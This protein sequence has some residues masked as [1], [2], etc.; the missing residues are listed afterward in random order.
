MSLSDGVFE[1]TKTH[2]EIREPSSRSRGMPARSARSGW[3]G[4][5]TRVSD[6]CATS[7]F[8]YQ[9]PLESY[10]QQDFF[11]QGVYGSVSL[12]DGVIEYAK[13]REG[14][15]GAFLMVQMNADQIYPGWGGD[16]RL[17]G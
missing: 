5:A 10:G 14:I 3:R 9:R 6:D 11:N 16:A 15:K 1:Y 17:H 2:E 7:T 4:S 8:Y 12:S 13:T